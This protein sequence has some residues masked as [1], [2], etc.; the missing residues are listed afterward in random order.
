[1]SVSSIKNI[2][3]VH[4]PWAIINAAGY[5]K[6]DQA[7]HE[8]SLCHLGNYTGVKNL[9]GICNQ[10]NVKLVTFSTDQVFDGIKETPYTEEDETCPLNQYGISKQLAEKFL[11]SA[12]PGALIIRTAAFFGPWDQYN[13]AHQCL[14]QL[15]K[16]KRFYASNQHFISPTYVP[17]L[18]HAALDLLID[19]ARGIYHL[20]NK[21]CETWFSFAEKL[22]DK[23]GFDKDLIQPGTDESAP[24][25]RPCFAAMESTKYG[26]MP[27]LDA[28]LNEYKQAVHALFDKP[29]KKNTLYE[30]I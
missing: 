11:M 6:L 15:S 24:A 7:E 3:S 17:H 5:V 12:L 13:F 18:A 4:K 2:V 30:R 23:F 26:L 20:T 25:R 28:A 1:S 16:G 19:E 22:A 9:A 14:W 21:G 29:R 10:Y 27:T 8:R